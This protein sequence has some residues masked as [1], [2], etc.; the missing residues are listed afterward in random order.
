MGNKTNF[1]E[2][3]YI[4]ARWRG[5][6]LGAPATNYFALLV[7]TRGPR[8]NTTAYALNDTISVVADDGKVHLYK[9]TTAGTSAAAQGSL[10]A[11]T[12]DENVTDGTAVFA[13]QGPE[14][15]DGSALV[16]A[17]YTGYA[18]VGVAS[19]LANFAG[20]QAPGSTTAS[21]GTGGQTSNN[22]DITFGAPTAGATNYA[23]GM[24]VY[25]AS[26]AGNAWEWAPLTAAKTINPDDS[27][28]VVSTGAFT[29]TEA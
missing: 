6:P 16:E 18:R 13:E 22:G 11:G 14:L 4:D 28:P 25:D 24:A 20:T 21:T 19:S 27:A 10:Y 15:D 7:S 3:K 26:S 2:N 5:Q 17:N 29:Y 8:A 9:C 23:W 1:A 12:Y